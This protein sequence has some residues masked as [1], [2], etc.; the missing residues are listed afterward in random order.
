VN[1]V[2]AIFDSSLPYICDWTK[3]DLSDLT[4]RMNKYDASGTIRDLN[5]RHDLN[6][7][8]PIL[9]CF[10]KLS[11]AALVLHHV[12]PK[13]YSM[14]SHHIASL[15]YITGRHKAGTVPEYYLEYCRELELW[16]ARFNLNVVETEFALWTWYWRAN[17]GKSEERGEHSR[18]FDLD[19]WVKKR[20]ALKIKDSLKVVDALGFARFFLDTDPTLGALIA[21]REF[22]VKARALLRNT[23][24]YRKVNERN[25]KMSSVIPLL[26]KELRIDYAPLWRNRDPV[27]HDDRM[28]SDEEAR[29][30]IKAVGQF[31][32]GNHC[33]PAISRTESA[34]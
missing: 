17:H 33:C 14:C 34:G 23:G 22:E 24:R 8:K 6:L 27:M 28:I 3:P 32:E 18:R 2:L 31:I 19:P 16:G 11:L 12:Y 1:D 10:R 13:K 21:W 25:F 4:E 15:L 5:G 30:V 20:R 9:Y 7:I 29:M 26:Q